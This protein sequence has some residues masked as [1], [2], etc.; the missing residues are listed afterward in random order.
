MAQISV[1][2][3]INLISFAGDYLDMLVK[4]RLVVYGDP[5]DVSSLMGELSIEYV[6]KIGFC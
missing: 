1:D 2:E 4:G 5:A 3:G 6:Y